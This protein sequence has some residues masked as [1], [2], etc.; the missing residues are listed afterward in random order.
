MRYFVL[1]NNPMTRDALSPTSRVVFIPCGIRQVFDEAATYVA[2]GHPLLTHPLAGSVKP[3]ETPYR[4]M[5][6]GSDASSD[7][8]ARSCRLISN[9]ID[10]CDKFTDRAAWLDSQARADLQAV[11]LAIIQ[12][13]LCSARV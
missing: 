8:D 5:L 12:S 2:Q 6:L 3:G 1:T 13:A 7:I 4:S 10:S 9:A 11:D